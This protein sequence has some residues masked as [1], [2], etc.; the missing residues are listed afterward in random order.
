M[1]K[2][3]TISWCANDVLTLD[4]TL[5]PQQCSDVLEAVEHNHDANNGI[6]WDFI[7]Y[8]IDKIKGE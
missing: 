4:D 7:Q 3:I 1:T 5:T 8:Y 6:N 2:E